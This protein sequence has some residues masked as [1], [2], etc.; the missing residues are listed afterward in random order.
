MIGFGDDYRQDSISSGCGLAA[1]AVQ[2][3]LGRVETRPGVYA[4]RLLAK[5]NRGRSRRVCEKV[6]EEDKDSYKRPGRGQTASYIYCFEEATGTGRWVAGLAP[7]KIEKGKD[8]SKSGEDHQWD[9][10]MEG[11]QEQWARGRVKSK[12]KDDDGRRRRAFLTVLAGC[13]HGDDKAKEQGKELAGTHWAGE[14]LQVRSVV[15]AT[16]Y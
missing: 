4:E 14:Y 11:S 7:S 13:S 6:E 3:S 5:T 9:A 1:L 15:M 12:R 16:E 2:A 8:E 10:A